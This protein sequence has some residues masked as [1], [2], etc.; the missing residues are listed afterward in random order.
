MSNIELVK[1]FIEKNPKLSDEE[2]SLR[3]GISVKKVKK[4]RTL[5]KPN[6][7]KSKLFPT[8][9]RPDAVENPRASLEAKI[10]EL[11]Q[12]FE[13]SRKE[14]MFDPNAD[15]AQNMNSLLASI[16]ATLKEL[17]SFNDLTE[18]AERIINEVLANL[19][20]QLM[21]S[22]YK[23]GKKIVEEYKEYLPKGLQYKIDEFPQE[24]RDLIGKESKNIYDNAID[25]LELILR[26]N[27]G[28]YR[29]S[30]R[31]EPIYK[32]VKEKK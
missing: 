23:T 27:L 31:N 1:S 2:V 17:D 30:E 18:I 15:N 19:T 20:K 21:V 3:L 10:R 4:A 12:A 6:D 16:K 11:D 25:N 7:T 5:L 26:V 9:T 22:S 32:K 13:I 24:F 8:E 14:F 29:N 28:Q